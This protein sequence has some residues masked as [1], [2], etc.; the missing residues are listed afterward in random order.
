MTFI[1]GVPRAASPPVGQAHPPTPPRKCRLAAVTGV[2]ISTR[3]G[4]SSAMLLRAGPALERDQVRA[5]RRSRRIHHEE[6]HAGHRHVAE[7]VQRH[8]LVALVLAPEAAPAVGRVGLAQVERRGTS[9][10]ADSSPPVTMNVRMSRSD[11]APSASSPSGMS[12]RRVFS[13]VAMSSFLISTSPAVLRSVTLAAFSL[14][15]H[16]G[17]RLAALAS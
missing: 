9:V 14:G 16:A 17:E 5:V 1:A 2:G 11:S 13:R 6:R 8:R 10:V 15:D 3:F 12:E 7:P 4:N